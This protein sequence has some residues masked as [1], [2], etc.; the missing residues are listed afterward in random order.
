M[1]NKCTA[2]GCK[3][4]YASVSHIKDV[5]ITFHCYP[6]DDPLVC[7]QWIRANPKKNFKPSTYS[8]ICSLHFKTTDFIEQSQDS[9]VTR[10]SFN[11]SKLTKRYLRK[12]AVP[13]IFQCDDVPSYLQR[14]PQSEAKPTLRATSDARYQQE[15]Q[16][17]EDLEHSFNL[18]DDS[19][20]PEIHGNAPLARKPLARKPL[21]RGH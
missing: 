18:Q 1:V 21:A 5:S 12:G 2:F 10:K 9:N 4:N 20:Y 19:F 16:R 11:A 13:S 3:S 17:Q 14:V 6:L 8:R 7:E 15:V